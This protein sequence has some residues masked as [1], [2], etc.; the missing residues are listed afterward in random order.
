[1]ATNERVNVICMK[2]GTKFPALYVNRL[3]SMVSRHLKRPHRF[4]CFTDDPTGLHSAIEALPLP[5]MDLPPGKER[6]WRKLSTFQSPLADL[7]GPTLFLD[8]DIVILGDLDA[9]FEHPGEFCIIHDWLRPNRIEGNS[10]VYR[11]EANRFPEIYAE[12]IADIDKV[13]AEHRHEQSYLSSAVHR[14]GKLTYWPADWC[15]SFK[16]HCLLPFPLSIWKVPEPPEKAKILVFHG[17][18]TPEDALNGRIRGIFRFLRPTRWI[19]D[20]WR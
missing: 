4:V 9:F 6:G 13:K 20:H 11:F 8:V 3:H 2:W 5:P 19:A 10:S 15:V 17:S 16:R 18:P 14:M 1:M 12:F 7:T